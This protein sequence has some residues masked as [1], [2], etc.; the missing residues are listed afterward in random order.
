[1]KASDSQKQQQSSTQRSNQP[2]FSAKSSGAFFSKSDANSTPFFQPFGPAIQAKL[3][4]GAV[5]DKY[6][7]E[8]DRVAAD[9][10]AKINNSSS[11]GIGEQPLVPRMGEEEEDLQMQLVRESV[12]RMEMEDEELKMKPVRESVQRIGEEEKALQ[13]Q[14]M[15]QRM[16]SDEGVVSADFESKL[17]A[18]RGAGQ[19]LAPHLQAQMGQAIGADFSGVRVHIDGQADMLN[20]SIGSRAFTTGQDLFFKQGEYQPETQNGQTLIAHELTHVV[21]QRGDLKGLVQRDQGDQHSG[22]VLRKS[23]GQ[24]VITVTSIKEPFAVPANSNVSEGDSVTFTEGEGRTVTQLSIDRKRKTVNPLAVALGYEITQAVRNALGEANFQVLN[25]ISIRTLEPFLSQPNSITL[26]QRLVQNLS[27]N[28]QK[29]AT[30]IEA[31][32]PHMTGADIASLSEA[33]ADYFFANVNHVD[34]AKN[35]LETAQNDV[36]KA[37]SVMGY[38]SPYLSAS[39]SLQVAQDVLETAQN[40]FNKAA[41]VMAYLKPYLVRKRQLTIAQDI[42]A[43]HRNELLLA[44]KM[45]SFVVQYVAEDDAVVN[46]AKDEFEKAGNDSTKAKAEM[47]TLAKYNYDTE[48]RNN[49][50]T[51]A[52]KAAVESFEQAKQAAARTKNAEYE[53]ASEEFKNIPHKKKKSTTKQK[54]AH[55]AGVEKRKKTINKADAE[56]LKT[57]KSAEQAKGDNKNKA[58]QETEHFIAQAT[59]MKGIGAENAKWLIESAQFKADIADVLL[60]WFTFSL[61]RKLDGKQTTLWLLG[62]AGPDTNR[63]RK[64][65]SIMQTTLGVGVQLNNTQIVTTSLLKCDL[66]SV[67]LRKIAEIARDFWKDWSYIV[68]FIQSYSAKTDMALNVLQASLSAQITTLNLVDCLKT[69]DLELIGWIF[70]NFRVSLFTVKRAIA[71]LKEPKVSQGKQKNLSW[72]LSL[73]NEDIFSSLVDKVIY[74]KHNLK[75]V[76]K[77]FEFNSGNQKYPLTILVGWLRKFS[78]PQLLNAL[79]QTK[80]EICKQFVEYFIN[81]GVH[82]TSSI[83]FI[84]LVRLV[85]LN[86]AKSTFAFNVF[87]KDVPYRNSN[88][89]PSRTGFVDYTFSNGD[90]AI[91]HTHWNVNDKKIVSMHIQDLNGNNGTEINKFLPMCQKVQAKIVLAHNESSHHPPTTKPPKGKLS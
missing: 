89:P 21:Q 20:H 2:F 83:N 7:Q 34:L 3:T 9:V 87:Q 36:K 81:Y 67:Q 5:G 69:C 58:L 72:I 39:T 41:S 8:A 59:Q 25:R 27:S 28:Y 31:L 13:M 84:K 37:A 15:V 80:F 49:A 45:M 91:I 30:I 76:Q 56:E 62:I 4:V 73:S 48:L 86:E 51:A 68:D 70:D 47:D 44:T 65:V 78:C 64:A 54:R 11:Q 60:S 23:N 38:L 29:L 82:Q 40:N 10:V 12:Q 52:D 18:A 57:I 88:N 55:E 35:V 90:R 17:N 46:L 79:E 50:I 1:M 6:E 43:G 63:L 14:P 22:T 16:G 26:L 85:A 19:N 42:L 33:Q 77:I 71:L 66:T 74:Y 53:R 61:K 24:F 32:T 75:S